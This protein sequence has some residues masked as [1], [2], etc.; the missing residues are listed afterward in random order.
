MSRTDELAPLLNNELAACNKVHERAIELLAQVP[1]DN[2]NHVRA[3]LLAKATQD[4]MDL[5]ESFLRE[6]PLVAEARSRPP[7]M[8]ADFLNS[9]LWGLRD[10]QNENLKRRQATIEQ[11]K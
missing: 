8:R 11:L 10:Q 1:A 7:A 6:V 5:H 3:A 2:P 4:D 9:K